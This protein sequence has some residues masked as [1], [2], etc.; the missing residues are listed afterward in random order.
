MK[1]GG[2]GTVKV[3]LLRKPLCFRALEEPVIPVKS[4]AEGREPCFPI[5]CLR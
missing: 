3:L 4:T 1:S 2:E 5:R